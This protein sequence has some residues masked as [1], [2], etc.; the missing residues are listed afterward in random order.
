VRV[1]FLLEQVDVL[2]LLEDPDDVNPGVGGTSY[3]ILQLANRLN[4]HF[5]TIQDA[6]KTISIGCWVRASKIQTYRGIEVVNISDEVTSSNDFDIAIATGGALVALGAGQIKI[7]ARKLVAWIHHPYDWEKINIAKR[8]KAEIV[9]IGSMQYLS[10]ALIG[11]RHCR[12]ENIFNS[13]AIKQCLNSQN[14]GNIRSTTDPLY[15]NIGYMGALIPSKGFH[16]ILEQW[17]EI[18]GAVEARGKQ[19]RLHVIGGSTLYSYQQSHPE[20]PCEI[21]YGTRI[22]KM[23]DSQKIGKDIISFYGVM[24]KRRYD[25]MASCDVAIVN[26]DGY[27]EAFPATILEWLC[28]GVPTITSKRFGLSDVGSHLPELCIKQSKEIGERLS[29]VLSLDQQQKN[30]LQQKCQSVAS[31]YNSKQSLIVCQWSLL[32]DA[33][34]SGLLEMP[35]ERKIKCNKRLSM[36]EYPSGPVLLQLIRDYLDMQIIRLKNTAKAFLPPRNMLI[37]SDKQKENEKNNA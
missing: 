6:S 33:V 30:S 3:L 31:L 4:Q 37:H 28:L 16:T 25:I 17:N 26:P 8:L 34:Y 15:I 2:D 13:N 23:I 19:M 9:S 20:L 12:I 22:Q 18:R 27:G 11:G 29:Y 32:L 5:H 35:K 14:N 21:E 36:D 7:N 1:L 24:D 10:N